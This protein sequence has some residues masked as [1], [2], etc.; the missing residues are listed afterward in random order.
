MDKPQDPAA[1]ET[2]RTTDIPAVD[3]PRLVRLYDWL[4]VEAHHGETIACGGIFPAQEIKE[5]QRWQGSSGHTV[6][7]ENVDDHSVYYSWV[8]RGTKMTHDKAHFAFQCRY[9]LIL[10][11]TQTEGPSPRE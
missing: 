8:E 11:N 5:G 6:T 1:A 4:R 2:A 10:P 9:C 3:L 7:V